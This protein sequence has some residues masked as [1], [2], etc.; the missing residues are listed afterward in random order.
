MR[1]PMLGS[2]SQRLRPRPAV[3]ELFGS[4]GVGM[5][6]ARDKLPA[7]PMCLQ[8]RPSDVRG[9]EIRFNQVVASRRSQNSL[10]AIVADVTG[11]QNR[12]RMAP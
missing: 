11:D 4:V 8:P 12:L 10:K 6:L 7:R 1:Q 9:V 3:R 2:A 5:D